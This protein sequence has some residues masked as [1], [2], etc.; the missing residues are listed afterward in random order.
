MI[1]DMIKFSLLGLAVQASDTQ[2]YMAC[3]NSKATMRVIG[4]TCHL[5][6]CDH[7]FQEGV[8]HTGVA[9]RDAMDG[10]RVPSGH[11]I[12]IQTTAAPAIADSFEPVFFPKKVAWVAVAGWRVE[13][14]RLRC[15]MGRGM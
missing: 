10:Q 11:G 6:D 7:F 1:A 12:K 13:R 3:Y 15:L 5:A 4:G 8:N 2:R 14:W 9:F